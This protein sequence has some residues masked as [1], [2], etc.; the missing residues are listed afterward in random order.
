MS[1]ERLAIEGGA[2][3]RTAPFPEWPQADEREERHLLE[4]LRS[5]KWSVFSGDKVK[6]FQERFAAYQNA[7]FA[8]CLP[9]GTLGLL[10]A[11]LALGIGT[12][13]EV[14]APAYTFIASVSP[15]LLLGAKPVLVDIDPDTYTLDPALVERAVTRRTKAIV[16]VHLAGRPADMDALL[17]TARGYGLK[18]VEDACQAWGA[19]WKGQRVGALGDLGAFSFQLGKNLTAGEGGALVTNDPDL[20]E[21]VWSLHN[22]GRSRSEPWYHHEI[23]GLNLRMTE[24]QGAV[25]LAQLERLEEHYPRRE[26]NARLLEE[27]LREVDGLDPLPEDS[28]VTRHARH[29]VIL[30]YDPVKFGGRPLAEFLRALQAEG[31]TP[32]HKGYTP[33][34]R[35]PAIRKEMQARFGVD[36]VGVSLPQAER[37]GEHTF[38]VSQEALLGDAEDML[39]MAAAVVKIQRAWR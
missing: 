36:P 27:A 8:T 13:D 5:R 33:L 26:K 35:T 28:R 19:E 15:A 21:R 9:N 32:A 17:E 18:V 23:L 25:L 38:W 2:P 11:F 7:R 3:L 12:G 4:V 1:P 24:W 29:L 31:I 30:R 14:I 16:P 37:A 34:H 20:H 39:D 10:A 22:V 6:T